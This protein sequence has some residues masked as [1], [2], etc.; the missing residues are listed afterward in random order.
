MPDIARLD[1]SLLLVAID[2]VPAEQHRTDP[3]ARTVALP[4]GHDMASRLRA[5]RFDYTRGHFIPLSAEPLDAAERDA[6]ELIEGI[7][8]AIEL[9]EDALGVALPKRTK[10]AIAAFRRNTPKRQEASP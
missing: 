3:Q 9:L 5:Y 10:R 4:P 8:E 1:E 6:G 7:V 2:T